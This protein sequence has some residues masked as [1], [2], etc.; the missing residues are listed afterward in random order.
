[1]IKLASKLHDIP[2]SEPDSNQKVS[3]KKHKFK[4]KFT[5]FFN[6]ID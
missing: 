5:K 1:M 3:S 6:D 2:Q 4:N